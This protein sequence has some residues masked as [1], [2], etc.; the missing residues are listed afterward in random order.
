[1]AK[2][3]RSSRSKSKSVRRDVRNIAN[4]RLPHDPF[5]DSLLFPSVSYP[6]GF[7]YDLEDFIPKD[8]RLYDPSKRDH[9]RA[10][11]RYV[12]FVPAQV[13]SSSS[14]R[15]HEV[16]SSVAFA[17]PQNIDTCVRRS[18]RNEV[19]HAIGKAGKRGQRRPRMNKFS[20]IIC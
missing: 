6:K 19:I 15:F 2:R 3:R 10:T 16:P 18:V 4:R 12:S 1:M 14:K 9:N 7:Q 17:S 20:D 5:M 13:P 8:N 11:G